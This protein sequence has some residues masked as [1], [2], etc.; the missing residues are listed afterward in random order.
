VILASTVLML[1]QSVTDI[2]TNTDRQT[3]RR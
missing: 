2:Q 3:T 1:S